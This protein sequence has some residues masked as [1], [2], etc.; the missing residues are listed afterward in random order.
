MPV[1][2]HMLH[3]TLAHREQQQLEKVMHAAGFDLDK[4]QHLRR[5]RDRYR[6][7]LASAGSLSGEAQAVLDAVHGGSSSS[8]STDAAGAG[9]AAGDAE[10]HADADASSSSPAH[11]AKAS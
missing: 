2:A 11:K 6:R 8:S 9:A 7:Y 5:T 10:Q 3:P 4:Y 1:A